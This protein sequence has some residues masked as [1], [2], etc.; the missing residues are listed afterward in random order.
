[1]RALRTLGGPVSLAVE[2]DVGLFTDRDSLPLIQPVSSSTTSTRWRQVSGKCCFTGI[3]G[4]PGDRGIT[5]GASRSPR[6]VFDRNTE[7]TVELTAKG[8]EQRVGG[9]GIGWV[10]G[11]RRR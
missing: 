8:S 6:R 10:S 9:P 7:R 4:A 1:V 3:E 11:Y 5:A 2:T